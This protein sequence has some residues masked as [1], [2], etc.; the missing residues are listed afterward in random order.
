MVFIAEKHVT[1]KFPHMYSKVT[2]RGVD[3]SVT[4]HFDKIPA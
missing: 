1:K 2:E 3:I 4:Q